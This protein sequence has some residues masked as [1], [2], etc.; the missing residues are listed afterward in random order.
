MNDSETKSQ[1]TALGKRACPD[2]G[3]ELEWNAAKQ[4]LA[5]PYCG[6]VPK[7]QPPRGDAAGTGAASPAELDLERALAEAGAEGRGYGAEQTVKVKCQSCQAISVFEPTRVAQR[8][9]F[10]G[11]PA[12][13]P[14]EEARDAITPQ[15]LLPV[16]VPD[17][18]VRDILRRWYGSHWLAPNRL[19][20]AALTDTVHGIYLPY[21]TFDARVDADWT[22]ESG[23]YYWDTEW[24]TD[25]QG[26]RQTRQVRKVRWYPSAGSLSHFFDDELVPGSVG[27]RI[28]LLRRVEPF[29][30][31]ELAPYDPAFV[32]GWTVERYQV[33]L[34][35]ASALSREQIDQK[36]YQL[37]AQQVPGDTH[38]NLRMD[39]RHSGRTFKHILVPV[40][41]VT[42]NFGA[43]TFQVIV[44][45]YTGAVAGERP[46][47]WVKVLL[48]IVLPILVALGV[49]LWLNSGR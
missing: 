43:K 28:D 21:W 7:D 29:P 39:A 27:V 36:M 44:N 49:F 20:S 6:F 2:C 4:V 38:R 33:D 48:Y 12:I 45:G 46:T 26:R 11:S 23:D 3:G 1:V 32:R 47:S 17:T 5:C 40:W 35:Q 15:S 18:Q 13:V 25:S 37:C 31:G 34:R 42:Y 10:C 16:R 8:C 24:Y 22:A 9:E 14:Y 30:T 41:V 19:K